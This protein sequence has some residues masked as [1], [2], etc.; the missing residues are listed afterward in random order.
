[1]ASTLMTW[2]RKILIKIDGL[3]CEQGMWRIRSNLEIQNMY[4]SPDIVTEIKV[5]RLEWLGHVVRM[6]DTCLP[7]MVFNAKPEG[8]RRVGRPRM[9]WLDNVEADIKVLGVKRWRIRAQ[10]RKEWSVILMEAKAK[11]KGRDARGEEEDADTSLEVLRKKSRKTSIR[12]AG[13]RSRGLNPG[14]LENEAGMLTIQQRRSVSK[15]GGMETE[16]DSST[17]GLH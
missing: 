14:L 16:W 10:D 5:R 8:R 2:E 3:K 11:L 7:K 6:E 1:M 15:K 9:R 12:I 4:K 17:S 13:R